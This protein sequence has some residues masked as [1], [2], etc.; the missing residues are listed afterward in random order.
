MPLTPTLH[1]HLLLHLQS[2]ELGCAMKDPDYDE[3]GPLSRRR[4]AKARGEGAQVEAIEARVV[5][6]E[7]V[8]EDEGKT[9]LRKRKKKD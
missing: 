9:C 4:R 6:E 3:S 1:P 8:E 5:E 7:N 2:L